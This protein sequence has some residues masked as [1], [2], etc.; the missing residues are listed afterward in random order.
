MF[1]ACK[2]R[3]KHLTLPGYIEGKTNERKHCATFL[4][5]WINGTNTT[6]RYKV[7]KVFLRVIKKGSCGVQLSPTFWRTMTYIENTGFLLQIIMVSNA[8]WISRK[9]LNVYLLMFFT[10]QLININTVSFFFRLKKTHIYY[11]IHSIWEK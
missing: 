11:N 8:Y 2:K 5:R 9:F 7:I 4:G 1:K 3:W 6:K 10:T